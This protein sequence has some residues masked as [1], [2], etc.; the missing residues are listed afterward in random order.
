MHNC[1]LSD[2]FAEVLRSFQ[3]IGV[4][5]IRVMELLKILEVDTLPWFCTFRDFC[6]KERLA[7]HLGRVTGR[8]CH[9]PWNTTLYSLKSSTVQ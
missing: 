7:V 3:T 8:C 4:R 1:R 5:L 2:F 9:Y 6:I